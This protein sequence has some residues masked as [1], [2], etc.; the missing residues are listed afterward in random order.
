[1][2]EI[3]AKRILTGMVSALA[4]TLAFG[5]TFA[6]ADPST[7][8]TSAQVSSVS[9]DDA[10]TA[11]WVKCPR[12]GISCPMV[13]DPVTCSNGQTYSNACFAYV[14]CATGCSGGGSSSLDGD[15]VDSSPA[16][17]AGVSEADS[18]PADSTS[19]DAS[20]ADDGTADFGPVGCPRRGIFCPLVYAP[21]TCDNGQTYSNA[22]FAYVACAENCTPDG[23]ASSLEGGEV[24]RSKE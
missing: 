23:G 4:L 12:V 20:P 5:A 17:D 15:V 9:S 2:Q 24:D 16:D 22:C 6:Q 3:Y 18:S 21:V 8:E 14:A 13:Y 10:A 1:M 11:G 7:T 19:V